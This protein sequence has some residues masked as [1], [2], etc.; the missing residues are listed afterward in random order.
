MGLRRSIFR[1]A[2]RMMD[3]SNARSRR[4]ATISYRYSRTGFGDGDSSRQ[5]KWHEDIWEQGYLEVI[6]YQAQKAGNSGQE[7]LLGEEEYFPQAA[8]FFCMSSQQ[9]YDAE[10]FVA[11]VKQD[12]GDTYYYAINEIIDECSDELYEVW[13]MAYQNEDIGEKLFGLNSSFSTPSRLYSSNAAA[14][15]AYSSRATARGYDLSGRAGSNA[16][17]MALNRAS[18]VKFRNANPQGTARSYDT[19][20]SKRS[21]TEST[22]ISRTTATN[23]L[24]KNPKGTPRT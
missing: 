1:R 18:I 7:T 11:Y 20:F 3:N 2:L 6:G 5:K 19:S 23:F 4:N 22:K 16:T 8:K 24:S 17:N 14:L 15:A 9:N 12:L 13:D 21:A 10:R